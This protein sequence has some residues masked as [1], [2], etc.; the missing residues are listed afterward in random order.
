[1]FSNKQI[2]DEKLTKENILKYVSEYTIY[3]HYLP[4]LEIGSITTSPFRKDNNP[5]FGVFVGKFGDLAYNDFKIGGGDVISFVSRIE[6]VT[7]Y[8]AMIIIN[9]IF[10]LGL[11]VL[12][13]LEYNP[14]V[15]SKKASLAFNDIKKLK[16]KK[17]KISIKTRDWNELDEEYLYPLEISKLK[18]WIPLQFF[19]LDSQLFGAA[20]LSYAFRY[21]KHIYK[22]YQPELETGHGKWWSNIDVTNTWY[23]HD[24]LPEKGE[25]L[26]VTSS[27]KDASV[28]MQLGYNAIAP[29]TE[30]QMFSKEQYEEY[31]KRFSKIIIFYDNDETGIVRAEKFSKA[32]DLEYIYLEEAETKDPFEFVK[33]YSMEDLNMFLKEYV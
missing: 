29:H 33:T 13:N 14:N 18:G 12:H 31:S 22:I 30:A 2:R 15:K 10:K 11:M 8:E 21:D 17:P 32:F 7:R 16:K 3:S 6:N 1:M 25:L 26:I 20:T 23:G 28:L 27:N 4:D 5:S 24:F 9:R 19:W